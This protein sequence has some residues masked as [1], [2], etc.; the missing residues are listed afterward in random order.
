[1]SN[2]LATFFNDLSIEQSS[3]QTIKNFEDINLAEHPNLEVKIFADNLFPDLQ[4]ITTFSK[5]HQT[6]I[7]E[8]CKMNLRLEIGKFSSIFEAYENKKQCKILVGYNI[9]QQQLFFTAISKVCPTSEFR[10]F[11]ESD[12]LNPTV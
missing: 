9:D 12:K 4:D 11:N 3:L 6:L 5:T 1:M 2:Y 8:F 7:T 10:P